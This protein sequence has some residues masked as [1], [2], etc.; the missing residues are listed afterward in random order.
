MKLKNEPQWSGMFT[1]EWKP[2]SVSS[3]V[4]EL[5]MQYQQSGAK[6]VDDFEGAIDWQ[7]STINGTVGQ[8]GLPVNPEEGVLRTLD[9]HSPHD[10]QGMKIIWNNTSGS[11]T[12]SIPAAHKNVSAFTHLSIRISQVNGSNSNPANLKQNLRIALKDGSNNERAIR[13]GSFAIIPF[14]DQRPEV[15][16]R[17]SAM[18]TVRIPL[19]SYTIV[20]AGQVKVD[21]TNISTLTLKFSET[22]KGEI[23]IDN[24]EFTN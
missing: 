22:L 1:G 4:A 20:C 14:P 11:V 24:V 13:A 12:F 5:F 17:K 3:T 7:T 2:A 15:A 8:S 18:V 23:D 19:T 21:L 6:V 16:T 9:P 10:T